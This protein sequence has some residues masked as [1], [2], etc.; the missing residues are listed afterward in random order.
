MLLRGC[1]CD[2]QRKKSIQ[3][4]NLAYRLFDKATAFTPTYFRANEAKLSLLPYKTKM[5]F[6]CNNQS[7]EA[8]P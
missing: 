4:R 5:S 7:S 1:N 3:Q 8:T 2:E 6:S